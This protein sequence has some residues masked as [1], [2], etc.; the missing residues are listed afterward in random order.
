[1]SQLVGGVRQNFLEEVLTRQ[2]GREQH[3]RQRELTAQSCQFC[4]VINLTFIMCWLSLVQGQG[5]QW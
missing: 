4:S 1:M 3:F 5:V 2:K